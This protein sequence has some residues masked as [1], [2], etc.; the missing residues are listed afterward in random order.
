MAQ[1]LDGRSLAKKIKEELKIKIEDLKKKGIIPSLAVILV[2]DDPASIVYVNMK[3]KA[4]EEVGIVSHLYHL[5]AQTKQEEVIELVSE[6]GNRKDVNGILIQ[7]PLPSHIDEL[8][9][10]SAIPPNKDVDGLSPFSLGRLAFGHPT[11]VSCTALGV[12]ELLKHYN[13]PIEGKDAVVMGRSIIVGKPIALLLLQ[14]NATVTICHSKTK[15]IWDKTKRADI[16]V[17]A[18]GRA[19]YVK[20]ENIKEGAVVIDCG[21]NRPP[22]GGKDVGDVHFPSAST[23]AGFITPVPGGVGPMTIAMLLKNTIK[24]VE[25]SI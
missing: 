13:I 16:L 18:I 1:I 3:R 6:L 7:H 2:G 17:V 19:E 20:G 22:E 11:F 8:R 9:V 25:V 10:F 23:V 24:S 12:L 15:D 14:H 4:C 21:Y 5:P